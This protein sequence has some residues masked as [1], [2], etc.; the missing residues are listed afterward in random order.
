MLENDQHVDN[1]T[2][3]RVDLLISNYR[4]LVVLKALPETKNK[5][6]SRSGS[7]R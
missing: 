1:S 2:R 6:V 7:A 3:E 4:V 5:E